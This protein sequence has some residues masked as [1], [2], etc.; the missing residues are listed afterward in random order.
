[1]KSFAAMTLCI[2]LACTIGVDASGGEI[3][4]LSSVKPC[5]VVG[6]QMVED[7]DSASAQPGDFFRFETINA[8]T[9]GKKIV[10]PARTLGYGIVAVAS[11]AGSGG[12]PGVLVLEPRYLDLPD[13]ARLGVVLDH[14]ASDLQATGKAGGMPGYLGAIPV[15]MIGAAIGIFNFFHHGKNILV[16]KGTVFSIFPADGPQTERCQRNPDL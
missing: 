10:I 4:A 9:A 13:H 3:L 7:V 16:K 2:F 12:R 8:V 14:N 15:P 11:S 1:M 6:V 5:T